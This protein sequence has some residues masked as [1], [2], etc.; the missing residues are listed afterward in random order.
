MTDLDALI[1]RL[2][3]E[4]QIQ[5]VNKSSTWR[6]Y[7]DTLASL[8]TEQKLWVCKQESVLK[9]KSEMYSQFI[10]Y[11][12]EL[13]RDAFVSVG[14]GR[15]KKLCENY[16]DS[17][18]SSASS[19]VSRSEQLEQKNIELVKQNEA[20]QRKLET[21]M[22]GMKDE[23]MATSRSRCNGEDNT[24]TFIRAGDNSDTDCDS[25]NLFEDKS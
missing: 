6:R 21:F 22:K 16:I 19:Y 18:Q 24:Q 12:F 25:P 14:D 9:A 5:S 10:D 11:L 15:Y 17:I 1:Q 2:Q 23:S 4:S 7:D 8:S 3:N 13:N 20:L